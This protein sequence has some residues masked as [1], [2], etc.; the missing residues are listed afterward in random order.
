MLSVVNNTSEFVS[1]GPCNKCNSSDACSLFSDGHTY[2]FSCNHYEHGDNNKDQSQIKVSTPMRSDLIPPGEISSLPKRG[3]T[4][5]TCKKFGYTLGEH[6][7]QAVQVA[8]YRN[9]KN[10][11][12]AQKLRFA[13]KDFKFLGDTKQAGLF[14][15]HLWRSG[16]KMLVITEGE[17]DCL[18]ANQMQGQ[19]NRFPTVSVPTGAAG[20]KRAIAKELDW[21]ESHEK[22]ILMFDND[23]AGRAA[24]HEVAHLLSPSKAFIATLPL[25]DPNEML[26]AGKQKEFIDCMWGAKPYRPDGIVAGSDLWELI[27]TEDLKESIPYPW[28]ELNIK[29]HG[30]RKGELITLTAGSGVGKSQVCKELAYHLINQGEKIGYIALEESCKKT[31]LDIMSLSLNQPLHLSREGVNEND[32]RDAFSSTIG[33]G[34]VYLYDHFGSMDSDNLLTKIRYLAKGFN[35]GWVF[36]DH[37]SIVISSGD[38]SNGSDGLDE[39][40]TIDKFMTLARSLVE[41]TG[42]GMILVSHL[43]KPS[44]DKGW[45]DGLQTSLNALRSSASIGQLSDICLGVERDQQGTSPNVSTIR[46]LKNRF[47]GQTGIGCY[48]HYD[49]DSSRMMEVDEATEAFEDESTT[50]DF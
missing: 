13:N 49:K 41:E 38:Y 25:K 34:N 40:K 42:I 45:E 5:E 24:S 43:R 16:S 28:P 35:V 44:G 22:V 48:L 8:S 33:N 2:C 18:A 46:V 39:R 30:L 4:E 36:L 12:V 27:S 7:G 21:V 3:I 50:T 9:K 31:A 11:I 19:G 14:G 29:T 47:S 20:A 10:Q 32:L 37:L 23:D 17:L 26:I 15:Q 6:N 1:H